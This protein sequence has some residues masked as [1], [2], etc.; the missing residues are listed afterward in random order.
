MHVQFRRTFNPVAP[1]VPAFPQGNPFW[2]IYVQGFIGRFGFYEYEFPI[3]V[4][5]AVAAVLFAVAAL[6]AWFVWR[7]VLRPRRAWGELSTYV[8]M[9]LGNFMLVTYLAYFYR[10]ATGGLDFEQARYLFP[11][12]PLYG[13]AVAA[14]CRALGPRRG[15][16]LGGV[17]VVLAGAHAVG[18]V[19]L[20]LGR[21][22][23]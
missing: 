22:Y 7:A 9:V 1:G 13:L 21:F 17:L 4:E 16:I 11:L 23:G 8:L 14:A 10:H 3:L 18:A 15:R 19:L 5:V 2:Q 6:G 20:T 12:I